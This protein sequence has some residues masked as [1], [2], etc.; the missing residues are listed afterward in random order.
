MKKIYRPLS[1]KESIH[2]DMLS[3]EC[4]F[5]ENTF[6]EYYDIDGRKIL[7][8]LT[9]SKGTRVYDSERGVLSQ[10]EQM[11][12]CRCD[13]VSDVRV[14]NIIRINGKAYYVT[15]AVKVQGMYWKIRMLVNE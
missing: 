10:S 15:E 3:H 11:F 2:D 13:D 6:A 8:I 12:M 7:G 9:G 5:D 14:N 1:V 4:F